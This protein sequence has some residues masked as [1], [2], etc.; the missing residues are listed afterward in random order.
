MPNHEQPRE[1]EREPDTVAQHKAGAGGGTTAAV[2]TLSTTRTLE[3]D[4]SGAVIKEL[5][6]AAGHTVPVHLVIRDDPDALRATVNG[7]L[8]PDG[9]RVIVLNGGTGLA[10]LD[11][12]VETVVPM[13]AKELTGFAALFAMLSYEQVR[14]AAILSRATAGIIRDRVLFALPGS[15]KACR[16]AME[17]LILPEI[18]HILKQIG[19]GE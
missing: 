9:P 19:S 16:L 17:R 14:S 10:P 4:Q 18:G 5:L 3:N 7:L 8:S 11:I 2:V 1:R 6:Q 15:P 13:F 12:T